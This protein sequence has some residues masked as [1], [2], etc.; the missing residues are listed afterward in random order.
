MT[1]PTPTTR[2]AR[3]ATTILA[4]TLLV[5][6]IAQPVFAVEWGECRPPVRQRQLPATPVPNRTGEGADG[7]A[8]RLVGLRPSQHGQRDDLVVA[9]HDRV[10]YPAQL[11]R[12]R[13]RLEGRYRVRP[14]DDEPDRRQGLP[15]VLP[16]QPRWW[17]DLGGP[18]GDTSTSSNIHDQA[19]ARHANGRV[20]IAWTGYSTGSLYLRTSA[21][22][23]TTSDRPGT[24]G[25][26]RT[27]SPGPIRSIGLSRRSRS[28][29]ASPMSPTCRPP[30][31]CRSGVRP[32]RV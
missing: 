16:A 23:G 24:S 1:A 2:F 20:T 28:A 5:L 25:R 17:R 8:A 29:A 7:L 4:G 10:R 14:T 15:A 30:T 18:A 11:L 3:R 22:S 32:T 13:L 9:D 26:R 12:L 31:R 21:D 19:L 6:L 27:G